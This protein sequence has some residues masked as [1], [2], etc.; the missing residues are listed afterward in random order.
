MDP[1]VSLDDLKKKKIL[2]PMPEL[3]PWIIQPIA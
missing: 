3:K 1:T 2:L